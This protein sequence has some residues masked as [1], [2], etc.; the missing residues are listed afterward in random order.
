MI[1]GI[2]S[3]NAFRRRVAKLQG[4][5]G[6][7]SRQLLDGQGIEADVDGDGSVGFLD[8]IEIVQRFGDQVARGHGDIDGDGAI[9]LPDFEELVDNFGKLARDLAPGVAAELAPRGTPQAQLEE[10]RFVQSSIDLINSL[11]REMDAP[12]FLE[13][14]NAQAVF[15]PILQAGSL[16]AS[17]SD[18][19]SDRVTPNVASSEFNGVGSIE[20]VHPQLGTFMCTGTVISPTHVLTAGHCF[21]VEADGVPDAG[22][23]GT[24][25][26][27]DGSNFSS[28]HTVSQVNIHPD[29]SGFS[30]GGNDDPVSYTHLTLPTKA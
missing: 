7:E 5:E 13:L 14:N 22:V 27:H 9:G 15:Y 3:R 26:L 24:F 2:K 10:S 21:D 25:N 23:T 16:S 28:T 17:P 30:N 18:S 8:Y 12:S 1:R 11:S 4:M 6:L 20:V 19:P 29:F